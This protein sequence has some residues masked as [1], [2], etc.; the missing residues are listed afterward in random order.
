MSKTASVGSSEIS[1]GT[2]TSHAHQSVGTRDD[3][4]RRAQ[5]LIPMLRARAAEADALRR[6]PAE[7]VRDLKVSGIARVLQPARYGGC[8]GR[9]PEWWIS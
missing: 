7:T 3:L 8:R 2:Q 6:L 4:V 1:A 9:S 5:A